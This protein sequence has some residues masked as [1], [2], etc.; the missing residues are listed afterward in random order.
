[1]DDLIKWLA[2]DPVKLSDG[3]VYIFPHGKALVVKELRGQ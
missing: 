3:H 1:M 2:G